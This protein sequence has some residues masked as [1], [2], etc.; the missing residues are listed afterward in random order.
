LHVGGVADVVVSILARRERRA[1]QRPAAATEDYLA[2]SILA[3]RERRAHPR[4]SAA[5][6]SRSTFQSSPGANAGRIRMLPTL[7]P[8]ATSFNPR[9][10]RTPG[11]SASTSGRALRERVSI[12]ARRERRAHR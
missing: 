1:H 2:V 7:Q 11:A 12:L 4:P 3:R 10:A 9:P 5:R 6:I 8:A